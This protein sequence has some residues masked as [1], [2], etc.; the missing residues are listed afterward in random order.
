[1][2]GPLAFQQNGQAGHAFI[3]DDADFDIV[4]GAGGDHHRGQAALKEMDIFDGAIAPLEL[5]AQRQVNSFQIGLK[6]REV[7]RREG[8]K[9]Q[10]A[11]NRLRE[12]LCCP[13][14]A[15]ARAAPAEAPCVQDA[16]GTYA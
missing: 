4:I 11:G 9:Y 16:Q 13:L 2:P 8:R 1:M 10:V 3:A 6:K 14:R 5:A 12:H 15:D 7:L